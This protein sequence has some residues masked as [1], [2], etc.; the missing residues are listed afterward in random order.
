[1]TNSIISQCILISEFMIAGAYC[2]T[3]LQGEYAPIKKNPGLAEALFLPLLYLEA[4]GRAT[5][6]ALSVTVA[7]ENRPGAIRFKR[8][9]GDFGAAL[10][11]GPIAFHHR[12]L[13]EVTSIVHFFAFCFA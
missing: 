12:A 13:T 6:A 8:Q 1:M 2:N 4:S 3:P 5:I 10:G 9:F 11:A 7:A